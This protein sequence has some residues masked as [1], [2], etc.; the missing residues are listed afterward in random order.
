MRLLA[1]ARNPYSRWW[2]W[3]PGSRYARP[4]MTMVGKVR[5]RS[6]LEQPRIARLDFFRHRLD[7]GGVFLHQLDVGKLAASRLRRHLRMRGILR[8]V[9][10]EELLGLPRVQPRLEQPRRVRIGRGGEN[11]G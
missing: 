11:R 4:G 10:D 1:Q 3:I 6:H 2:L 5:P 9:I 8:G 7:A